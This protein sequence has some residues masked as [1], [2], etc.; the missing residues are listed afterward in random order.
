[1]KNKI[2]LI[3][4]IAFTVIIA[5]SMA[6][7]KS[8]DE[9]AHDKLQGT[10]KNTE[11]GTTITYNFSGDDFTHKVKNSDGETEMKG[12]FSV[13]GD[14]ITFNYKTPNEMKVKM[15]FSVD[16]NTLKLGSE[17]QPAVLP[18]TKQ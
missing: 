10:W 17:G 3:S 16:G 6:A 13:S 4:V 1:M 12:T 18:F 5:F 2:K 8:A 15:S 14:T 7:C 9:K 11:D